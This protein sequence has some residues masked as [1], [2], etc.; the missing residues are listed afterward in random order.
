MTQTLSV[1]LKSGLLYV[2]GTVNGTETTWTNTEGDVWET[3]AAR[4]ED[5]VYHIA[6]TM[7][8]ANGIATEAA[9][10]LYYGI[11]NLI[12]DRT[13]ADVDEAK[14]LIAELREGK[15]LTESERA[16]YLAGLRGCYN[17]S[18]MNR[19]GAAMEYI[20]R[21]MT[22]EGYP[23]Y[24]HPVTDWQM[25]DKIRVS[26]WRHYLDDMRKIRAAMPMD[27]PEVADRLYAKIDYQGA[28]DIEQIIVNANETL[29]R[30]VK[31]YIYA[32]EIFAG[33]V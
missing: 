7:I 11:L 4:S 16:A 6:L 12:T 20:D 30:I 10:T 3:T 19:V 23:A 9:L 17:A 1:T 2:T 24:V 28:N 21:R 32:G 22:T 8:D 18:D 33:E 14:R 27:A 25:E 31:D 15:A 13:Q 29:G 26:D 5:D